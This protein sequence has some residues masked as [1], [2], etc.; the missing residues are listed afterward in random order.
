[1]VV[2]AHSNLAAE[3]VRTAKSVLGDF[4]SV[5]AVSV[6]GTETLDKTKK[7][8]LKAI[9]RVDQG[10]GTIILTDLM[11]GTA[12]NL[13]LEAIRP[14]RAQV[15]AGVN[16]PILIKLGTLRKGDPRTLLRALRLYG[17]RQI[18]EASSALERQLAR[19]KGR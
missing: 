8:I 6:E 1:V 10:A 18:I 9:K 12:T 7:R 11:G 3:L 16:L 5:A 14:G 4:P 2:V 15:L 19:R 17:R 13:S